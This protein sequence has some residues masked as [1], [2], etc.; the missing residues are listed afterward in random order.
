MPKG[1]FATWY[2][3]EVL[4]RVLDHGMRGVEPLRDA[5]LARAHG[6]VLE[7]GFGTGANLPHLP[8]AVTS[9]VAVEPSEGLAA[10]ARARLARWDRPHEVLVQ[11]GGEPL[12]Y[13]D[14]SFDVAV[15]T[16]VLCS[17]RQ[18]APLLAQ[19]RRLLKPGAPLLLAEHIVARPAPLRALQTAL[20]PAWKACL[21]G[22]DPTSDPRTALVDAGF[23]IAGLEERP[24]DMFFVVRPGLIGVALAR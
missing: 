2:S 14:A 12:P 1:R 24:L 9:L 18:A 13:P 6:R 23:D 15:I 10:R 8:A 7:I 4:S 3:R 21:G 11:P 5:L 16:F 17:V 20:R 22:C 19:T